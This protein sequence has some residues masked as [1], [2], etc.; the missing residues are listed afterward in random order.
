[1]QLAVVMGGQEACRQAVKQSFDPTSSH[2]LSELLSE[3]WS[4]PLSELDL[5]FCW[6]NSTS[7]PIYA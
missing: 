6:G 3:L 4:T 1:M 7:C 5:W 2:L